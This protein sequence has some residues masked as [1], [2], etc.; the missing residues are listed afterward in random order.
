MERYFFFF[1]PLNA[2]KFYFNVLELQIDQYIMSLHC[3]Q[4]WR[5]PLGLCHPITQR[6][7]II[8]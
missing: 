2:L 5:N 4:M 1:L 3:V 7:N 6:H 8:F